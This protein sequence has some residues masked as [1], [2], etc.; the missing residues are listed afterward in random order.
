[1]TDQPQR[2]PRPRGSRTGLVTFFATVDPKYKALVD[3]V[4]DEVGV[5]QGVAFGLLLSR[6]PLDDRGLPVGL[7]E[8][9]TQLRL[10]EAP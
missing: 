4:A 2:R 9:P 8:G 5:S 3:R 7:P 6:V 10:A 1:M